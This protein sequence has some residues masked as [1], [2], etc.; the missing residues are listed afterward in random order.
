MKHVIKQKRRRLIILKVIL[1]FLLVLIAL[2]IKVLAQNENHIMLIDNSSSMQ[3]YYLSN[4]AAQEFDNLISSFFQMNR[5]FKKGDII[6]VLLF[7]ESSEEIYPAPGKEPVFTVDIEKAVVQNLKWAGANKCSYR[8]QALQQAITTCGENPAIIW[9]LTDNLPDFK[10]INT[11]IDTFY[12]HI[13]SSTSIVSF[14]LVP[15]SNPEILISRESANKTG[16]LLYILKYAPH[17]IPSKNSADFRKLIESSLTSLGKTAFL[18]K[19]LEKEVI[20]LNKYKVKPNQK[21][22]CR[23]DEIPY[24]IFNIIKYDG[25][26]INCETKIAE[27]K[28]SIAHI[29]S[30]LYLATFNSYKAG[31]EATSAIRPEIVSAQ[32]NKSSIAENKISIS[33]LPSTFIGEADIGNFAPWILGQK[34]KIWFRAYY[35]ITEIESKMILKDEIRSKINTINNLEKIEYF[36]PG[37]SYINNGFPFYIAFSVYFSPV[38]MILVSLIIIFIIVVGIIYFYILLKPI[39]CFI[40]TSHGNFYF[41]ISILRPYH[42]YF[43]KKKMGTIKRGISCA[44]KFIPAPDV[45]LCGSN[46][47]KILKKKGETLELSYQ[48]IEEKIEFKCFRRKTSMRPK[49]N[50]LREK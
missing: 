13:F 23:I 38:H 32:L 29:K 48:E 10:N 49:K 8:M 21:L 11:H 36:L 43:D 45:N 31:K 34:G 44:I 20:I 12:A 25:M 33:T 28:R 18:C 16:L 7:N 4:P 1:V 37:H 24:E 26:E 35:T 6:R 15:I 5:I 22:Q 40:Y 9:M 47:A 41:D 42:L 39:A 46:K 3:K 27:W 14:Y 50:E 30:K 17:D 2:G 19:P